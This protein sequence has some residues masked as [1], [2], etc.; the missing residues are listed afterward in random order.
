MLAK[1]VHWKVC[2]ANLFVGDQPAE[3]YSFILEI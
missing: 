1:A 3:I 2:H